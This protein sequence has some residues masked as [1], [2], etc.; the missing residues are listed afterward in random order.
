MTN[1]NIS[2]EVRWIR[3]G[4]VAGFIAS[5]SYPVM[6]FLDMPRMVTIAVGAAFGPSLAIASVG[7]YYFLRLHQESVSGQIGAGANLLA[8]AL[9]TAMIVVQLAI[10]ITLLEYLDQHGSDTSVQGI[11]QWVWNVV[12]GLDVTFDVFIGIGTFCF[13]LRMVTHPKFGALYGYPGMVIAVVGLLGLNFYT[14]P[15]PPRE[16]G[17]AAFEP[18]LYTG[19]WYLTVT[20]QIWRS[21][22]WVKETNR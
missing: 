2:L 7:L 20:I 19:L 18:G 10:R 11:V 22:Q 13:A 3:I 4:I 1:Q 21:L 5:V 17:F 12:L 6:S 16:S 8:G 15:D 14:F 9:V